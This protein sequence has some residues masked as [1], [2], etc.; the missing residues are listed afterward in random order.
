LPKPSFA[1]AW[2]ASQRIDSTSNPGDKVAEVIGGAV[3]ANIKNRTRAGM[4]RMFNG[5]TCYD[6]CYSN[7]PDAKYRTTKANFWK[8]Q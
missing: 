2:A 7:E 3:A 8:L 5:K 4:R 1:A 6:H